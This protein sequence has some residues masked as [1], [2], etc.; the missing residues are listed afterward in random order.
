MTEWKIGDRVKL[1]LEFLPDLHG[2]L[3]TIVFLRPGI[4]AEVR[5]D[6]PSAVT[7]RCSARVSLVRDEMVPV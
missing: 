3:A 1:N 4:D 2:K 5:T 7:G 6:E